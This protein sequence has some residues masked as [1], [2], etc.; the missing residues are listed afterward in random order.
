MRD[1]TCQPKYSSFA[2]G[3][4]C[5]SGCE[6]E[7]ELLNGQSIS[8]APNSVAVFRNVPRGTWVCTIT[9]TTGEYAVLLQDRVSMDTDRI[10]TLYCGK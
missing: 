2:I 7:G 5:E 6:M 1:A 10:I 4:R 3:M 8:T 9:P